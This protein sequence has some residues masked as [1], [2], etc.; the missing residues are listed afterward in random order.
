MAE[1]NATERVQRRRQLFRAEAARHQRERVLG[2]ATLVLPVSHGL[3]TAFLALAVASLVCFAALGSYARREHV[4]GFLIS[5]PGAAKIM[6]PRLGTVVAVHVLEGETVAN[7]APL[8]TISD[9]SRTAIG[10]DANGTKIS[11]L[12]EQRAQLQEQVDLTMRKAEMATASLRE[13]IASLSRGLDM[14]EARERA[15][16]ERVA[17]ARQQMQQVVEVV[18]RGF[19]SRLELERR[20]DAWL[21]QQQSEQEVAG[22]II[23]RRNDLVQKRNALRQLPI[24]NADL[25]SQLKAQIAALDVKIVE[26]TQNQGY[27]LTSPIAGHVSA[28]QAW[29]GKVVEP[30]IPALTIVPDGAVLVGELLLPARAIG[31]VTP[32]QAVRIAFDTFP[33]QQFGFADGV[34]S[35]VSHTLLKPDELV[36]P[37]MLGEP[38]YRIG[39]SLSRQS[40]LAYGQT[41]PLQ[42]DMQ[43]QA[44]IVVRRRRLLAWIFDP[45][46]S[47]WR[48]AM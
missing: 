15:Q 31:F 22:E 38:S 27:L 21:A 42:A 43:L 48:N 12:R 41:I 39:F 16:S 8:L 7:G 9:E 19:V 44:D 30:S 35:T 17:V 32:G 45:L 34:V 3:I 36:G 1:V 6:P 37:I 24:D 33:Y 26:I 23:V 18:A 40:M 25:V 29:V 4:R 47:T 28:L 11:A 10:Q 14:L 5:S 2:T 46:L 13:D 20:H